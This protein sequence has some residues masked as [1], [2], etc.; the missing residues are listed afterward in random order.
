M[1]KSV[2]ALLLVIAIALLSSCSSKNPS[3]E[4]SASTTVTIAEP[5]DILSVSYKQVKKF[6]KAYTSSKDATKTFEDFLPAFE[7]YNIVISYPDFFEDEYE[8]GECFSVDN[9]HKPTIDDIYGNDNI[10]KIFEKTKDKYPEITEEELDIFLSGGNILYDGNSF[11]TDTFEF[12]T[13]NFKFKGYAFGIRKMDFYGTNYY[14]TSCVIAYEYI[15]KTLPTTTNTEEI[16]G[17][18]SN[19]TT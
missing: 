16:T 17:A 15:G 3:V 19:A 4:Q 8:M 6:A 11:I 9:E 5:T 7:G 18:T 10:K 13:E 2:I 1:K 12:K 14:I